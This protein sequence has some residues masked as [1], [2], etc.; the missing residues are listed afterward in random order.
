MSLRTALMSALALVAFAGNSVQCRL[1]LSDGSIDPASFTSIRLVSGALTLLV[2]VGLLR[3]VKNP[4]R[5]IDNSYS[6]VSSSHNS[7]LNT[8]WLAPIMLFAYAALFSFSYVTL[9]TG[10]GALILF[11]SVQ[12]SMV[13][14]N[15]F[16][17]NRL[18][19]FE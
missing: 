17:G 15:F 8:A 14:I 3:G 9:E 18:N 6:E 11:G 19:L 1:A 13:Y 5:V 16:R 12:I 4:Y 2:L 10:V 7:A